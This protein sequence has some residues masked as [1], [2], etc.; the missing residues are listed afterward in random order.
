MPWVWE[1]DDDICCAECG[2]V[3][4]S[5]SDLDGDDLC[6]ACAS[7]TIAGESLALIRNGSFEEAREA[8]S[9]AWGSKTIVDHLTFEASREAERADF[10]EAAFRLQLAV[11]PKWSSE[12]ECK[13]QYDAA[14]IETRRAREACV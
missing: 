14:M 10:D 2:G 13:Q 3:V 7:R 6:G 12:E 5:E 1:E 11:E 8:L 9:G 4:K